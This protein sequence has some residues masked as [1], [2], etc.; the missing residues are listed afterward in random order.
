VNREPI[1]LGLAPAIVTGLI[2]AVA[3][4][5]RA[6]GFGDI[7]QAQIDALNAAAV[8]IMLVLAA[9]G[10]WYGRSKVTPTDAAH[11]PEGT[12]VTTTSATTGTKTGT[13]TVTPDAP[14]A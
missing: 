3:N 5:L 6:F 2:A 12:V 10:A 8:A 4:V 11:L 7:T 14:P 9:L 13:T 1:I